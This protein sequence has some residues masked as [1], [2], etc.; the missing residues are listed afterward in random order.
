[1]GLPLMLVQMRSNWKPAAVRAHL[2]GSSAC[3]R[4]KQQLPKPAAAA[5]AGSTSLT[6]G[7]AIGVVRVLIHDAVRVDFDG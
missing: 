4:L 5:C 3:R 2:S 6:L 7:E 1:M